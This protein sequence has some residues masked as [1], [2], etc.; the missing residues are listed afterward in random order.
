[1]T[2]PGNIN[3]DPQCYYEIDLDVISS[4]SGG[5]IIIIWVHT[6]QWFVDANNT[7]IDFHYQDQSESLAGSS[8]GA[9]VSQSADQKHILA[10]NNSE[11]VLELF[12]DL[13]EEEGYRV[14]TQRYI[15]KDL[16]RIAE[17]GP[18]VII[19]EYMWAGE[20][21]GWSLLQ[22]LQMNPPTSAIP[23]VLCTGAIKQVSELKPRLE[24]KGVRVVLKPF[25]LDELLEVLREALGDEPKPAA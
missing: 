21:G 20:D 5:H 11:D 23:I 7:G 1:M 2:I 15:D 16:E 25:N 24:E 14:T 12:R 9:P 17:L 19:L 6:A 4:G 8:K 10:I 13:L 22:M 18:D 3:F